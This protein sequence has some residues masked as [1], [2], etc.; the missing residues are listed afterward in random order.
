MSVDLSQYIEAPPDF[1]E[2]APE[3]PIAQGQYSDEWEENMKISD[4]VLI[5]RIGKMTAFVVLLIALCKVT[6]GL[7][8]AGFLLVAFWASLSHRV[9]LSLACYVLIPFLVIMNPL[10]LGGASGGFIARLGFVVMTVF[11]MAS[12]SKR[13]G[14]NRIPFGGLWL[15]VMVALISSLG[16]YAPLI[17]MLKIINFVA[18]LCGIW[19]GLRNLDKDPAALVYLRRFL[20]ALSVII[21][22]GSLATLPFPAIAYYTSMKEAIR[23]LGVEG[24]NEVGTQMM[25]TG[26]ALFTGITNQ[27]QCM[28]TLAV[29]TAAWVLCDMLFVERRI[30]IVHSTILFASVPLLYMTRSRGGL[31]SAVVAVAMI[32]TYCMKYL[33]VSPKVK[34]ALRSGLTGALVLI[35]LVAGVMEAR[36]NSISKWLRKTNDVESDTRSMSEAFTASRMGLVEQNLRD[37]RRNPMFGSGFQVVEAF[38]YIY[39]PNQI[40]LSAPI[41][42]GVMPLMILGETGIAGAI[43]FVIFLITFYSVCTQKRYIVTAALFTVL[44]ANNMGEATFFSTGGAGGIIWIMSIVGG[45]TIDMMV[46]YSKRVNYHLQ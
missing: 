15:Y 42:K 14:N 1:R 45:F 28:S 19:I 18:F 4:K 3:M 2:E 43:V 13:M 16:G 38:Q 12:A 27:S 8:V 11:L 6:H 25:N 17:S 20:L 34:R 37:F 22:L 7:A 23:V 10:I 35:A 30:S 39:E 41:E 46:L 24:A 26:V 44:M 21:I 36:D 33:R 40:V 31:L 29:M 32:Y 5:K 9:G